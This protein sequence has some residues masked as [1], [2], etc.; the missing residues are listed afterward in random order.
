M[1]LAKTDL[2]AMLWICRNLRESDREEIF[3]TRWDD[4][5]DKLAVEAFSHWGEFSYVAYTDDGEPVAVIGARPLWEGVWAVW[6]MAT[7]KFD[8]I[9]KQLTRW[10]RRVMLPSLLSAGMHRAE[11]RSAA[12]H[13]TAHRW[14]EWLGAKREVVLRQY[15]REK[16]DFV[17]F[18]WE[19]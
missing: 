17:L 5:A 7:D 6:M 1:K 18:A 10:A 13:T 3:A 9:G 8:I 2:G 16:Q 11:A 14:M 4:D 19:F 15:G 12:T